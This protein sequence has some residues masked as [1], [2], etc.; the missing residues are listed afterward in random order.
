MGA[1]LMTRSDI[2]RGELVRLAAVDPES[3]AEAFSRWSRDSE[4]LR[5]LDSSAA[6]PFSAKENKEWLEKQLENDPHD[7]YM[8]VI[9]TLRDDRLIGEVSLDG[10]AWHHGDAFVGISIGERE[11]WNKGY[12]TDA[13]RVILRYAFHELNLHRVTLNVFAYNH[14]AIRSYEKV[15]FQ[16][17]G[18]QREA[19]HR[20]G[21]RWDIL[22]MG[23]LRSEWIA[24]KGN[25]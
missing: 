25:R 8:F 1:K 5:L 21:R 16:F 6:R 24:A 13:M 12:G 7:L 3:L 15:G 2:F 22:Y 9:K 19:L 18:R 17:E 20:D 10:V 14:R 4:Y 23:I 11:S